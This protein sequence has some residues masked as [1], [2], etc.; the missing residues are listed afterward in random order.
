MARPLEKQDFTRLYICKRLFFF[1]CFSLK[2]E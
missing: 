2:R 1:T